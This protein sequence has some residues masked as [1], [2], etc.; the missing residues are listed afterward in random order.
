[1]AYAQVLQCW[2]KRANPPMP[3]QPCLLAESVLELC[4]MMEQY[5]SFSDNIV[6]GSVSLP[7][8]F[9]SSQTST[10]R[11]AL[12]TSTNV[13]AEEAAIPIGE[14]LEESTP[15]G[16]CRRSMQGW[17]LHQTDS[18]VGRRCYTPLGWSPQLDK[19]YQPMGKQSKGTTNRTL[20]QGRA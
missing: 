2:T 1:M 16:C 8:G 10:H 9:F 5:V 3:G 19:S 12:P 20:R 11:D 7:E 18:P 4:K 6:L 14:P 17:R 13:P 15:P